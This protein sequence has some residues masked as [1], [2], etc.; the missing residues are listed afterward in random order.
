MDGNG[1]GWIQ[2]GRIAIS[3]VQVE[4]FS[5]LLKNAEYA[6]LIPVTDGVKQDEAKVVIEYAIVTLDNNLLGGHSCTEDTKELSLPAGILQQGKAYNLAFTIKVN[7]V[8]LS[9]TPETWTEANSQESETK[10]DVP[11]TNN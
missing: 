9:A 7:A 6:F 1:R 8:E 2:N 5:P 4:T 10:I 11:K 3:T